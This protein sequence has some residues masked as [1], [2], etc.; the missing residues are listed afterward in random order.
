MKVYLNGDAGFLKSLAPYLATISYGKGTKEAIKYYSAKRYDLG[1]IV[2]NKV[3][4]KSKIDF[5]SE[6]D[7]YGVGDGYIEIVKRLTDD[8]VT[9]YPGLTMEGFGE[10]P[11]L[12][13]DEGTKI[14]IL[15]VD[16]GIAKLIDN[17]DNEIAKVVEN[18]KDYVECAKEGIIALFLLDRYKEDSVKL[19]DISDKF[20]VSKVNDLMEWQSRIATMDQLEYD[21]IINIQR[22]KLVDSTN[23]VQLRKLI[24]GGEI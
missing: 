11:K 22:S 15:T 10:V 8:K 19:S 13:K 18:Q 4:K 23:L 17:N 14:N 3:P 6:L 5:D 24:R 7:I 9:I 2:V 1:C 21:Y 12:I 16:N 20:K